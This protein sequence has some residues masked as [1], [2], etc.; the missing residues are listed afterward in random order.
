VVNRRSFSDWANY[1]TEFL[2]DLISQSSLIMILAIIVNIILSKKLSTLSHMSST[3]PHQKQ[4]SS[5]EL[6]YVP[7]TR[8]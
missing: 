1:I 2:I 6:H 5:T 8:K 3:E 7:I 4:N